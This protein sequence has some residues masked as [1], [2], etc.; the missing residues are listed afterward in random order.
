[1]GPYPLFGCAHWEA[2]GE[3]V[4]DLR[5]ELVSLVVVPD[6]FGGWTLAQIE[7]CFPDVCVPFKEHFIVDLSRPPMA[8]ATRHH[9]RDAVRALRRTEVMIIDDAP[10]FLDDWDAV[11]RVLVAR[12]H[13]R[14]LAAFS[15]ASFAQQL[16]VRGLVAFRAERDGR[17]VGAALWLVDGAVAHYHLAAYSDEGYEHGVSYALVATA[18]RHFAEQGIEWAALGAGAGTHAQPGDGL[19]RFKAGWATGTRTAYLCGRILDKRRYAELAGG[20]LARSDYFPA[21][22]A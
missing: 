16:Q 8:S 17:L 21:Y 11:Y 10:A 2:V 1:M 20:G 5:D 13:V 6:P 14:G 7:T 12:H 15:R 9:R 19:S 3:D 22:R 18:L 4:D